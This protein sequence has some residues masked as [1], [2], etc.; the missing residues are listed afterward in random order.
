MPI[1]LQATCKGCGHRQPAAKVCAKCGAELV[2]P[3]RFSDL[4]VGSVPAPRLLAT[5]ITSSLDNVR[6]CWSY[7]FNAGQPD[8]RRVEITFN[9]LVDLLPGDAADVITWFEERSGVDL[10]PDLRRK[11]IAHMAVNYMPAAIRGRL[12]AR[13][14]VT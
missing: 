3:G 13:L 9:E 4:E 6:G 11:L 5:S 1:Q 7:I 12:S 2:A 14:S 10:H 8:E